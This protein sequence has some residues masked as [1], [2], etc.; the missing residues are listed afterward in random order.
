MK[1]LEGGCRVLKGC[2]RKK[3]L[4]GCR[5]FV[6]DNE[7]IKLIVEYRENREWIV[8]NKVGDVGRG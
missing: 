4:F 7:I 3:E 6:G 5:F 8:R 1:L 2:F